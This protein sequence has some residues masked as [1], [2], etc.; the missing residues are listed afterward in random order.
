MSEKDPIK[1]SILTEYSSMREEILERI[2]G[3]GRVAAGTVA[4]IGGFIG[5]LSTIK[6]KD[7]SLIYTLVHSSSPEAASVFGFLCS[8]FVL[9]LELLLLFWFYQL[10]M[11]FRIQRYLKLL[12]SNFQQIFTFSQYKY[13]YGWDNYSSGGRDLDLTNDPFLARWSVRAISFVQPLGIYVVAFLGLLGIAYGAYKSSSY[14]YLMLIIFFLIWVS[15]PLIGF[16]IHKWAGGAYLPS[17][18]VAKESIKDT[19]KNKFWSF[20]MIKKILILLLFA[21][22]L[23]LFA[24]I[25]IDKQNITK[26]NLLPNIVSLIFE[27]AILTFLAKIFYDYKEYK[28]KKSIKESILSIFSLSMRRFYDNKSISYNLNSLKIEEDVKKFLDYFSN[29]NQND[30]DEYIYFLENHVSFLTG[31]IP[32]IGTLSEE[33]AFIFYNI[34]AE[35]NATLKQYAEKKNTEL[36]KQRMKIIS[37]IIVTFG[38]LKIK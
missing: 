7:E 29:S 4:L 21:I 33:H 32:S 2:R 10:F 23:I 38:K 22:V 25:L 15:I 11:M 20:Q 28:N 27:I 19:D 31:F 6:I 13:L 36:L 16:G 1:D 18:S 37:D 17:S 30:Y 3:Q 35:M 24:C 8:G 5:V 26:E 9:G 14:L 12:T 34:I